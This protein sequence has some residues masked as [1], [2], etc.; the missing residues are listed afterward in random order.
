MIKTS[1]LLSDSKSNN[2]ERLE[3]VMQVTGVGIWDWQ[4]QTGALTFNQRWVEIIGYTVEELQPTQFDT[5]A[6][7]LHPDDLIEAK[8]KL[9]QHWSGELEFY[10]VEAR[11]K[12]KEGGYV[13]VLTSGKVVEWLTN[14]QPKRMLGTHLDITE[15]KASELAS[16]NYCQPIAR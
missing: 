13:W 3:L 5:W 15:R 11:M 4:V 12:H 1:S 8:K 2:E 16:A 14:G 7:N 10:E 6:H 9:E